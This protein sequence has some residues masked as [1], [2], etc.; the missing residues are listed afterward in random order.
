MKIA[1]KQLKCVTWSS[2]TY[3]KYALSLYLA[4]DIVLKAGDRK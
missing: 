1:L 2:F 3:L 4:L